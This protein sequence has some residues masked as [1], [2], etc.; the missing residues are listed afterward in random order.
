MINIYS[1]QGISAIYQLNF[2]ALIL[3]KGVGINSFIIHLVLIV[4]C[5][6]TLILSQR[7]WCT[8]KDR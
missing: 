8:T 7:K 6:V 4:F 5:I 3:D 1:A 2:N